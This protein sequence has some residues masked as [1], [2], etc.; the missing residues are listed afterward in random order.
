MELSSGEHAVSTSGILYD[1]GFKGN[2][3]PSHYSLEV[4]ISSDA[5]MLMHC[6]WTLEDSKVV[7]GP[8]AH[9]HTTVQPVRPVR[10]TTGRQTSLD[11]R[12]WRSHHFTRLFGKSMLAITS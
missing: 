3:P 12:S 9:S 2:T 7:R 4:Y 1:E 10:I 5:D 6:T 11:K 8:E